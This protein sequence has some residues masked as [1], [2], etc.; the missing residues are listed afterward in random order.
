VT[1]PQLRRF[2]LD[3]ALGY[4]EQSPQ[5]RLIPVNP[6]TKLPLIKTGK[7]HAEGASTDPATIERWILH[8]FPDCGIAVVT[9]AASGVIV[10]DCDRKHDGEA[11]LR[12]LEAPNVLGPLP[13]ERVARTRSGGVHLYLAY[14]YDG[15]RVPNGNGAPS[16]LGRLLCKRPGVD[17]RADGGIAV[18]PPSLGYRWIVD[19]DGPFPPIPPLWLAALRGEGKP[20]P[21]PR[22][23]PAPRDGVDMV[24][25]IVDDIIAKHGAI[26]DGARNGALYKIGVRLRHADASDE[27]ILDELARINSALVTPPLP[28]REVQ[29]I[30][31]SAARGTR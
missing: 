3:A 5:F 21:R 20:A 18:L 23:P 16:G 25:G 14:P 7:D 4:T 2:L 12:A 19:D 24:G 31:R 15:I 9:G 11:L 26:T 17:V 28:D 8:R 13:R 27:R 10:I 30:A 22:R 1:A 29:K 6:T